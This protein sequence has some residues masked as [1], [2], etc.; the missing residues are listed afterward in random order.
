MCASLL[1][2]Q[3]ASHTCYF[4]LGGTNLL[5]DQGHRATYTTAF[6][7]LEVMISESSDHW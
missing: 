1:N 2:F 7:M 6:V 4:K 5:T 3:Y